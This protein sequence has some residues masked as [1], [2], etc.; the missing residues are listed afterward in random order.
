MATTPTT[1]T[2]P[3]TA[4]YITSLGHLTQVLTEAWS[5]IVSEP[6]NRSQ[7]ISRLYAAL[8]EFQTRFNVT[9]EVM[10]GDSLMSP[11][12]L[13]FR[14]ACPSSP[15]QVL[16][17][18]FLQTLSHVSIK[19]LVRDDNEVPKCSICLNS[20]TEQMAQDPIM[21]NNG[22]NQPCSA[23]TP[24]ETADSTENPVRL[25]CG[26][27]FGTECIYQWITDCGGQNPPRCPICR[28]E[29]ECFINPLTVGGEF[30][31]EA[32]TVLCPEILNLG[33]E[34]GGLLNLLMAV[35]DAR[36]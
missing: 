36:N 6:A 4:E 18:T 31:V 5:L 8:C 26:H 23:E 10:V 2:R 19:S 35:I 12:S 14:M 27:V 9:L 11:G 17:R 25:P 7:E 21:N 20:F 34:M 29:L 15:S 3:E 30:Y 32:I 13:Y 22:E 24:A 28:T 16:L 33:S 1:S